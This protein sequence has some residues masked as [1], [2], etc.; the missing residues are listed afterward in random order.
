[1]RIFILEVIVTWNGAGF[2]LDQRIFSREVEEFIRRVDD[3]IKHGSALGEL[4]SDAGEAMTGIYE[5]ASILCR[6]GRLD[7]V[8]L[9]FRS[10]CVYDFKNIDFVLGLAAAYQVAGK[11]NKALD[12]CAMGYMLNGSDYRVLLYAG[13]CNLL[14]RRLTKA[15]RCFDILLWRHELDECARKK[16]VRYSDALREFL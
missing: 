4:R 10:L 13:Q 1:M 2:K 7:E 6:N 14:L 5:R 8:E 9:L 3:E 12:M 16:I 11:Y 15:K